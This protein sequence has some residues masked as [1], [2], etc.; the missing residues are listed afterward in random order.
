MA[1]QRGT[2]DVR[3][4]DALR[5]LR[6]QR[7]GAAELAEVPP[8]AGEREPSPVYEQAPPDAGGNAM[9]DGDDGDYRSVEAIQG[10][11]PDMCPQQEREERERKGDLDRY[12]RVDGDRKRTTADL[13]VKKYTRTALRE[14]VLIRPMPVLHATMGHLLSLLDRPYAPEAELLPLHSFLWDRMRAVRMDLRMQHLFNAEAMM[15]HEQMVSGKAPAAA[16]SAALWYFRAISSGDLLWA[17]GRLYTTRHASPGIIS[18]NVYL[19]T[20]SCSSKQIRFHILAMHELCEFPKGEGFVEGFDAHLNIEQ[21]NKASV[22][23][24]EMYDDHHKRGEDSASEPEFRGYY[25][26][27]KVDRHPGFKVEPAE[28]SLELSRM[29]PEMRNSPEVRFAREVARALRLGNFVAFFRLARRAT[30]LQ[31]CLMHAHF[32]KMRTHALAAMHSS[33]QKMQG[34][35]MPTIVQWL[36]MENE[37]IGSLLAFHGLE[38][39][40]PAPGEAEVQMMK[41]GQLQNKDLDFVT[42]QSYLVKG[43]RSSMV[44]QDVLSH[45]KPGVMPGV[46]LARDATAAVATLDQAGPGRAI[47][48]AAEHMKEP[49]QTTAT[50]GWLPATQGQAGGFPPGPYLYGQVPQIVVPTPV[51][52][53]A[54]SVNLVFSADLQDK[55]K[56]AE[57]ERRRAERQQ[58]EAQSAALQR[59]SEQRQ[60]EEDERERERFVRAQRAQREQEERQ[61]KLEQEAEEEQER[62]KRREEELRLKHEQMAQAEA[63]RV[64]LMKKLVQQKA[65]FEK[66]LQHLYFR[67]WSNR[68]AEFKQRRER[69]QAALEACSINAPFRSADQSHAT[70][71][72]HAARM[73]DDVR[74]IWG[75]RTAKEANLWSPLHVPSL[76]LTSL[77]RQSSATPVLVWKL[78]VASR[79]HDSPPLGSKGEQSR[80]SLPSRWLWAKLSQEGG[81]QSHEQRRASI[82]YL[83][84]VTKTGEERTSAAMRGQGEHLWFIGEDVSFTKAAVA[85]PQPAK[86]VSG[87]IFLVAEDSP[88]ALERRRLQAM[89]N[90]LLPRSQVPLLVLCRRAP[91]EGEHNL[92]QGL[93]LASLDRSRVSCW[94]ITVVMEQ[95]AGQGWST[96]NDDASAGSRHA[97]QGRI[98]RA[99]LLNAAAP[100]QALQEAMG[101]EAGGYLSEAP[102]RHGLIWM[103]DNAPHQ[104][105]LRQVHAQS[106][107]QELLE[108]HCKLLL[109]MDPSKVTPERCITIFNRALAKAADKVAT[110]GRM[111]PPGWPPPEIRSLE[112]SPFH[113]WAR[114]TLPPVGWSSVATLDSILRTIQA[115]RLPLFD[116]LASGH[117]LGNSLAW[118]QLSSRVGGET[119]CQGWPSPTIAAGKADIAAQISLMQTRLRNYLAATLQDGA[120]KEVSRW[121]GSALAWAFSPHPVPPRWAAIFLEI[122]NLRLAGLAGEPPLMVY[123]VALSSGTMDE[124]DED[125]R[126][127]AFAEEVMRSTQP[128]LSPVFELRK[129][130]GESAAT[131]E[132][133]SWHLK[134]GAVERGMLGASPIAVTTPRAALRVLR[135]QVQDGSTPWRSSSMITK[136]RK[137]VELVRATLTNDSSEEVWLGALAAAA[138]EELCPFSTPLIAD[139]HVETSRLDVEELSTPLR[140]KRKE[141][142]GEEHWQEIFVERRKRRVAASEQLSKVHAATTAAEDKYRSVLGEVSNLIAQQRALLSSYQPLVGD[143]LLVGD[144]ESPSY[145]MLPSPH[146][147]SFKALSLE[148]PEQAAAGGA[149]NLEVGQEAALAIRVEQMLEVNA[150]N[151]FEDLLWQCHKVQVSVQK[152]LEHVIGDDIKAN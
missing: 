102:L 94:R 78:L 141:H 12:E 30:Y 88:L 136:S 107:V 7:F 96:T 124:M 106:L 151:R 50:I 20:V 122:F 47:F 150:A 86:G 25:A 18:S 132:E 6:L 152:E 147:D 37:D 83:A 38:A 57:E 64:A 80:R 76:V 144:V 91:S 108:P 98:Q 118:T 97:M 53:T 41:S 138:D 123:V 45:E 95:E 128:T 115:L 13:A 79:L 74:A 14:E 117:G 146:A 148:Q 130:Q 4:E 11:C 9:V 84:E 59:Q 44:V 103:A 68:T 33:L 114:S 112:P 48:G 85:S 145:Y 93:G 75:V 32:A 92:A 90:C 109:A 5:Q 35:S 42:S 34:V 72:K 23:L 70:V 3:K 135:A 139:R 28:L 133:Q 19:V 81:C 113:L 99:P 66:G 31:A 82:N 129:N 101:Q 60:R 104:P 131:A 149:G 71:E 63:K 49:F 110:T 137:Q 65:E 56:R 15:M 58:H 116:A 17:R 121:E 52:P 125:E 111:A 51:P 1:G 36:A 143:N 43:K 55:N 67:R 126:R 21:M 89:V 142:G 39:A 61:R 105:A 26:L 100:M 140:A 134:A 73:A 29:T 22:D 54:S 24:F 16:T 69:A 119:S 127:L 8:A 62:K 120:W 46:S 87:L 10:T 2:D 40:Q 27:L 77:R